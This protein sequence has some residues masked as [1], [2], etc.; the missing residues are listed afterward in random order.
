MSTS[1]ARSSLLALTAAAALALGA[2]GGDDGGGDTNAATT[3]TATATTNTGATG[4]TERERTQTQGEDR[5]T[6][7]EQGDDKG[8]GDGNGSSGKGKSGSDD[9][10]ASK[11]KLAP[12][13]GNDVY[14]VARRVCNRF[15]P[16]ITAEQLEKGETTPEKV[17]KDY[18]RGYPER[19]QKRV[20]DGCLKGLEE[21]G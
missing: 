21:R 4:T 8:G 13:E 14:S 11:G 6:T 19:Q 7:S 2:C 12:P 5:T 20:Y 9:S 18:A 15:L 1:R 16:L 3:D 17:A 10:G